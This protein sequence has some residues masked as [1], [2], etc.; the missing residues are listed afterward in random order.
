[1]VEFAPE[2]SEHRNGRVAVTTV[3]ALVQR[4]HWWVVDIPSGDATQVPLETVKTCPMSLAPETVGFV[5][6]TGAL[7]ITAVEA[8]NW[9]VGP[10]EFVATT[11]A[12]M[13]FPISELSVRLR[14]M[15]MEDAIW[16]QLLSSV[17]EAAKT[18]LVQTNH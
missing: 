1:M 6:A 9:V 17:L 3:T 11:R 12:S 7:V 18:W 16:L 2:I 14:V 5:V 15:A 13:Y 8:V 4:N 10:I